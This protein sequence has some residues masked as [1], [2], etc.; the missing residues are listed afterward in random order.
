MSI[1]NNNLINDKYT[2][3]T[4]SLGQSLEKWSSTG[5]ISRELGYYSQLS[6]LIGP[7]GF[8]TY[9]NNAV[10]EQKYLKNY[11]SNAQIVWNKPEKLSVFYKNNFLASC[12]APFNKQKYQHC[13]LIR[14]NQMSGAWAGAILAKKL[15]VPFILRCG[16]LFSSNFIKDKNNSFISKQISYYIEK[17][18][19][20]S[21]NIIFV[22]YPGAKDFFINEHNID[23]KK[24]HI[25]RNPID[26]EKFKLADL[27]KNRDVIFI[28]RF[29]DEKNIPSIIHAC[30][31]T[32]TSLTFVGDGPL[33]QDMIQLAKRLG[34]DAIFCDTVPNEKIPILLNKHK[35]FIIAS[36]FE[37]NPKSLLEAMSCE[38]PCIAS[39]IDEHKNIIKH[40]ENGLLCNTSAEDIAHS[41]IQLK[42]YPDLAKILGNKARQKIVNEY[43]MK[44]IAEKES[45]IHLN[46][47]NDYAKTKLNYINN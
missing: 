27:Q 2:L 23:A 33:K 14:S 24:I 47:I 19:A 43:S 15:R 29:S 41:I 6:K 4:M 28:G 40:E 12:A 37:G 36:F 22:T 31:K 39:N 1:D 32:N 46:L 7:L 35:I 9:S 11:I 8:L 25:L 42:Q 38:M 21:A 17:I 45:Q 26:I 5:H 10:L 16:Y 13:K 18:V 3:I 44:V 34:V 30:H 20:H